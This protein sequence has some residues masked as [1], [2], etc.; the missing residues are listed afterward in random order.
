MLKRS[1]TALSLEEPIYEP[2][3][4]LNE[5]IHRKKV[6]IV[7]DATTGKTSIVRRFTEGSMPSEYTQTYFE[8]S[9][10]RIIV[11][12]EKIDL[13]FFDTG[14][15]H[16]FDNIRPLNYAGA[17]LC[18]ITFAIDDAQSLENVLDR[19]SPEISEQL[20]EVPIIL[21]GTKE[22]QRKKVDK[23]KHV[24]YQQGNKI[25]NKINAKF[26]LECSAK[27]NSGIN[28]IFDCA[29]EIFAVDNFG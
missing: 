22:D 7:G 16:E 24:T 8:N 21:V 13:N 2:T 3:Y 28:E 23:E 1:S 20:A 19:W 18:I 10:K 29:G 14:G 17:D 9:K 26:Y 11:K 25:A 5:K 15:G 4:E 12:N 6:I 27:K